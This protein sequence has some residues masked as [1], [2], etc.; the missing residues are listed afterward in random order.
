[1]YALE[2]K[3]K[4]QSVSVICSKHPIL[5]TKSVKK[6][7]IFLEQESKNSLI[8]FLISLKGFAG[9]HIEME[10]GILQ[11]GAKLLELLKKRNVLTYI[12]DEIRGGT[13]VMVDSLLNNRNIVGINKNGRLGVLESRGLRE[14]KIRNKQ[15]MDIYK[16]SIE[17]YSEQSKDFNASMHKV[18]KNNFNA[19]MH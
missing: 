5:C 15:G 3:Q 17:F 8:I 18:Y 12:T 9:D 7:N 1:V 19:L 10:R 11:S 14:V 16:R 6:L 13:Y 2:E 4:Y